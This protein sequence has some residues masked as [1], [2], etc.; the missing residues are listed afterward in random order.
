VWHHVQ[1]IT[2]S[3]E[4]GPRAQRNINIRGAHLV[5]ERLSSSSQLEAVQPANLYR[6]KNASHKEVKQGESYKLQYTQ[7]I[8][9]QVA[10]FVEVTEL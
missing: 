7:G 2:H 10:R 4:G 6:E 9:T 3:D 8:H 1:E 5:L